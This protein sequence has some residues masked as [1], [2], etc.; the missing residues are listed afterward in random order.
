[1]LRNLSVI[2]ALSVVVTACGGSS[3]G[4]KTLVPHSVHL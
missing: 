1:M 2:L 3:S 4:K